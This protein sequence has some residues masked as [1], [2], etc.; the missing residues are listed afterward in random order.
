[1]KKIISKLILGSILISCSKESKIDSEIKTYL[2]TNAE[3]PKNCE[4]I[5]LTIIDTITIGNIAQRLK[6][7]NDTY[8]KENESLINQTQLALK[9]KVFKPKQNQHEFDDFAKQCNDQ[10]S[11]CKA[12]IEETNLD[13][14]EISK[15]L[16]SS[17][18][19]GYTA[20]YKYRLTNTLGNS[21]LSE[22]L[23]L[24]N[25]D[26]ILEFFDASL[27]D[28]KVLFRKTIRHIRTK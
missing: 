4:S 3:A 22:K 28:E 7:E 14:K 18:I 26:Y 15:Y 11:S 16:K 2:E 5:H 13:N 19:L 27:I 20:S 17:N 10:I 25:K 9:K 24:F 23:V 6:E 21:E 12:I 8:I 1:M